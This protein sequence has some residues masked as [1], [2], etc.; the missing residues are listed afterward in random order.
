MSTPVVAVEFQSNKKLYR[1]VKSLYS[2]GKDGV[3]RVRHVSMDL[4][5]SVAQKESHFEAN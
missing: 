1:L 4:I 2:G 5:I 3:S